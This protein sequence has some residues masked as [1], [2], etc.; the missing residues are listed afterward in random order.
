MHVSD[1]KWCKR[2][3]G[4]S[5]P[6]DA[7][8]LNNPEMSDIMLLVEGRP[9]YAHRV[10]LMSASKRWASI[11]LLTPEVVWPWVQALVFSAAVCAFVSTRWLSSLFQVSVP[12]KFLWVRHQH[13]PHLW[14]HI[15]HLPEDDELS[16]LWRDW[17]AAAVTG[18]RY[19]GKKCI[20]IYTDAT[21]F[22][23]PIVDPYMYHS[24]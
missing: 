17:R 7:H 10:L 23:H 5:R 12:A 13:H 6:P 11:S 21:S 14:H 20:V 9:F 19:G 4:L 1:S 16:V 2:H 15:Q 18:W 24:G 22:I 8:F 3:F